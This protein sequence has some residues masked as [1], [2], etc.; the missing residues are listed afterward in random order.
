[1]KRFRAG[2]PQQSGR[3]FL[4]S[5]RRSLRFTGRVSTWAHLFINHHIYKQFSLFSVKTIFSKF[6]LPKKKRRRLS[7]ADEIPVRSPAF[8][9]VE[10]WSSCEDVSK[11]FWP[12]KWKVCHFLPF[13]ACCVICI[14]MNKFIH[15]IWCRVICWIL[16]KWIPID[17]FWNALQFCFWVCWDLV[18]R[19]TANSRK[20]RESAPSFGVSATLR[21]ICV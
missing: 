14:F 10:M 4:V 6:F 1:M 21:V 5:G 17:S 2:K 13:F 11:S 19:R 7:R 18:K 16:N 15:F 20:R 3:N 9:A 12:K 8:R